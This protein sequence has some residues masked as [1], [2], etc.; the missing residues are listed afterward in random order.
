MNK[1]ELIT[2]LEEYLKIKDFSDTSK[3]G[4]QVDNEKE[5]ITRIAYSVDATKYIFDK[6]RDEKVD[7][8]LC[9]HGIFWGQEEVIT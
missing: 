7:L 5:E 1:K 4:L 9:H 3:N 8:L 6:A 2:Y